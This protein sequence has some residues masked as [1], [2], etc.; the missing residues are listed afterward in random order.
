MKNK[1]YELLLIGYPFIA[2]GGLPYLH[3]PFINSIKKGINLVTASEFYVILVFFLLSVILFKNVLSR[4]KSLKVQS[5]GIGLFISIIF[6][7]YTLFP[8]IFSFISS[9]F[10]QIYFYSFPSVLYGALTV[11]SI[12]GVLFW[13]RVK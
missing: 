4:L 10:F 1:I 2:L 7:F 11:T 3:Y 12:Y 9:H 13:L 8:T 6:T 5:I